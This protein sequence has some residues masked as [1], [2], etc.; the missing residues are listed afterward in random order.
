M[1]VKPET[2]IVPKSAKKHLEETDSVDWCGV[3]CCI[4][5]ALAL[6][7]RPLNHISSDCPSS[8]GHIGSIHLSVI[9]YKLKTKNST[10]RAGSSYGLTS[11]RCM[12]SASMALDL[13]S[14]SLAEARTS[15]WA[16]RES[17]SSLWR[18][19]IWPCEESKEAHVGF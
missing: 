1:L 17:S 12:M 5:S 2:F 3:T 4:K 13:R 18:S 7:A 8:G 6:Q 11:F 15:F 14:D 16:A 10:F 19:F 9:S